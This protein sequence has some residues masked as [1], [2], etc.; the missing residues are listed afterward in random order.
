[1][2]NFMDKGWSMSCKDNLIA[3]G[4]DEGCVVI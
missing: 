4:F 3:A 2:M 1:M